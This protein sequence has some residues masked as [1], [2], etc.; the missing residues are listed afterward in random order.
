MQ[1]IALVFAG[2]FLCNCVPHLCAGLTG[3]KFPTPLAR[4]RG[5]G[6]SPPLVNFVWGAFNLRLRADAGRRVSEADRVQCGLPASDGRRVAPISR[7]ILA[8]CG[9]NETAP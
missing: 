4:P 9:M 1:I 2:A 5:V 6:L 8:R 7:G 3:Q